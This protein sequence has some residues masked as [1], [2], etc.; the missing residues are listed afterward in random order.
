MRCNHNKHL[1]TFF[2]LFIKQELKITV[3][4]YFKNNK[5]LDCSKNEKK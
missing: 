5:D 4:V 3:N 2:I 1:N